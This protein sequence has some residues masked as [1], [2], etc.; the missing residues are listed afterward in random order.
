VTFSRH[1][2][3]LDECSEMPRQRSRK[4]VVLV[5]QALPAE[6]IAEV[7]DFVD[8]IASRAQDQALAQAATAA[9]APAVRV[10]ENADDDVYDAL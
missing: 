8:F 3:L 1:F 10:W 6:R 5:L 2:E 9:S 7:Q 4:G